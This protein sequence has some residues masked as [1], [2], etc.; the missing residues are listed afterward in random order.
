MANA[1]N[2]GEVRSFHGLASVYRISVKDFSSLVAL[3]N[4]IEEAQERVFQGLKERLTQAPIL[5][6]PNFSKSFE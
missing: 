2:V 3:L 1:Q 5:A 6:L 4:D